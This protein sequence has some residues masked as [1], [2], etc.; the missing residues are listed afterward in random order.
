MATNYSMILS[1]VYISM[2]HHIKEMSVH[3]FMMYTCSLKNQVL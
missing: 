1:Y 3:I 2:I